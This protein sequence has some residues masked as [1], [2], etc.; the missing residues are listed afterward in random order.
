MKWQLIVR[1]F[2]LRFVICLVILGAL[3]GLVFGFLPRSHNQPKTAS[4][5]IAALK[6]ALLESSLASSALI[7]YSG[8]DATSYDTL[9]S[10]S[11]E[12]SDQITQ[13]SQDMVTTSNRLTPALRNQLNVVIDQEKAANQR[14]KTV[15]GILGQ[16][17]EY[18]PTTD[19]A[20]S[21]TGGF[22]Q[23]SIRAAAAAKGLLSAAN[24]Q[25]A[26]STAAVSNS[27]LDVQTSGNLVV[28]TA[29]SNKLTKEASC[30]NSIVSQL[31]AN[32][33]AQVNKT[34]SSCFATYPDM[35]TQ[36]IENVT[37]FTNSGNYQQQLQQEIKTLS[38]QL[39]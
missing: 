3:Y 8:S 7:N 36:S 11:S 39:G 21:A 2:A 14:F 10:L 32:Q 4:Q 27:G 29:T 1:Q 25:T 16:P 33:T 22:S 35:R 20:T 26:G 19:L 28:E 18:D 13:I 37:Q 12:L 17:I 31:H 15:F 38:Q 5:K 30:F 34:T 24:N 9:S 23:L 6:T